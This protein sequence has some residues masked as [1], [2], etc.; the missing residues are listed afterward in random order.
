[1]IGMDLREFVVVLTLS[2]IA[3]M[4]AHYPLQ[5]R[6]LEGFDGFLS[7]WLAVCIGAWI[8]E[9]YWAIG[10]FE[11]AALDDSNSSWSICR[12]IRCR[13]DLEGTHTR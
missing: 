3:S 12:C 1:M 8:G 9:P 4:A 13:D 5:H 10:V 2:F 7:K 11:F 6:H